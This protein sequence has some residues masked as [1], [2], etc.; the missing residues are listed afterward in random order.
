M[1]REWRRQDWTE[2]DA[3][4]APA[5]GHDR[6]E[7]CVRRVLPIVRCRRRR[8][9][10]VQRA[11]SVAAEGERGGEARAGVRVIHRKGRREQRRRGEFGEYLRSGHT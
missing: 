5:P 2:R 1:G 3:A 6:T 11:Q 9:H 7:E 4:R 10:R 8:H